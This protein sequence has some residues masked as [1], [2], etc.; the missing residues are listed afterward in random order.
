MEAT[1][2]IFCA[3][4]H[5]ALE[6]LA[7]Q[8]KTHNVARYL[9]QSQAFRLLPNGS[10]Q[11]GD[12]EAHI[13]R[14]NAAGDVAEVRGGNRATNRCRGMVNRLEDSDVFPGED[15]SD[16]LP[17]CC[18]K[19][20]KNLRDSMLSLGLEKWLKASVQEAP[21]VIKDGAMQHQGKAKK[22]MTRARESEIAVDTGRTGG[23]GHTRVASL[24][25][26][27]KRTRRGSGGPA[28]EVEILLQYE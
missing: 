7:D 8:W 9:A 22:A 15:S 17:E 1:N 10:V 20:K 14:C 28:E 24:G 19:V 5:A 4:S 6:A 3:V 2:Q 13:R 27:G 16:C 26:L 11:E 18:R 12:R 25:N 21:H 23:L